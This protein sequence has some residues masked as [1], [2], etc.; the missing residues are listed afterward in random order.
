MT[1]RNQVDDAL[2]HHR[3]TLVVCLLARNEQA[4]RFVA[5]S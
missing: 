3:A 4:L 1:L 5:F 2:S